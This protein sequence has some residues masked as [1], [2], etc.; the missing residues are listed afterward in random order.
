[1]VIPPKKIF[2]ILLLILLFIITDSLFHF[3]IYSSG[4]ES[5]KTV[6]ISDFLSIAFLILSIVWMLRS[7]SAIDLLK[8]YYPMLFT[9]HP[10]PMWIYDL[11]SLKFLEVNEAAVVT[12]GFSKEEFLSMSLKNI[13]PASELERLEKTVNSLDGEY[14]KTETWLHQRKD[15]K[16]IY[17]TISS[18]Q[19]L[20]KRRRCRLVVVHDITDRIIYE[21]ELESAYT[22]ERELRTELE[23]NVFLV[24]ETLKEKEKLANIVKKINNIVIITDPMENITW[25]NEAFTKE[26]GY[27]LNEIKGKNVNFLYGSQTDK[28]TREEIKASLLTNTNK[29]LEILNYKKDGSTYWVELR[30][31]PVYNNNEEV[32][33][34]ISVQSIVTERKEKEQMIQEQ[35]EALRNLAWLNSHAL[36]KPLASILSLSDIVLDLDCKQCREINLMIK[37]CSVDLDT[38]VREMN[39]QINRTERLNKQ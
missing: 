25:V 1:M 20:Y 11:K 12:Y 7:T 28:D 16:F 38:S 39:K 15:G 8:S 18:N 33:E 26:T 19:I 37:K 31:S 10:D 6:V 14:K 17:V 27:E 4:K 36:R 32:V 23:R 9:K 3:F 29:S 21:G 34:Y 13:R 22:C 2:S 35:H 5:L 24:N 30:I